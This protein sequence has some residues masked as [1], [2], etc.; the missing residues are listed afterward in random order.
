MINGVLGLVA[1]KAFKHFKLDE[2]VEPHVL[3]FPGE[4]C[5]R[6]IKMMTIPLVLSSLISGQ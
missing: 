4:F 5:L 3:S 2:L 6:L 1:A